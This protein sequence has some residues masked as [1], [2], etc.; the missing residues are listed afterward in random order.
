M[1]KFEK[2]LRDNSIS[3]TDQELPTA[4]TIKIQKFRKI[5]KAISD[6]PDEVEENEKRLGNLNEL[7]AEIYSLIE[8]NF[9]IEDEAAELEKKRVA[10][11]EKQK[12]EQKKRDEAFAR[13]ALKRK[14][15]E[16]EEDLKPATSNLGALEKL[17]KRGKSIVSIVELK[18]AGFNT[19]FTSPIGPNGCNIG[20]FKLYRDDIFSDEFELSKR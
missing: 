20:P 2:I 17:H 13:A 1:Y 14:R 11:E 8:E 6:A 18:A 3:E 16:E 19:G 10:E 5:Q 9:D 7:D 12:Y 4:I 15:E